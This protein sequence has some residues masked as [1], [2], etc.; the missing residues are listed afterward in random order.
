MIDAL[1]GEFLRTVD[2]VDVVAVAPIDHSVTRL[3]VLHDVVDHGGGDRSWHHH[4]DCT[5][6]VE[7]FDEVFDRIGA[8]GHALVDQRGDAC[9]V[10]VIDHAFDVGQCQPANEVRS[11]P[12]ESDHS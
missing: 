11:H 5:R 2:G 1:L 10:A 8:N 7:L 6:P 4:P 9:L 3:K 12:S